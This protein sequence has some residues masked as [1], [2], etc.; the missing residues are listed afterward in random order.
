[1]EPER[2]A[3]RRPRAPSTR[4]RPRRSTRRTWPRIPAIVAQRAPPDICCGVAKRVLKPR[5]VRPISPYALI[6]QQC[7][8][9][10][11]VM[12]HAAQV[13]V[14]RLDERRRILDGH[15]CRRESS[16]PPSP[17]GRM[18]RPQHQGLP[19]VGEGA[20]MLATDRDRREAET[21]VDG[22]RHLTT[23]ADR[24]DTELTA[25]IGAP[26]VCH[27][28]GRES[29]QVRGGAEGEGAQLR[30]RPGARPAWG[31]TGL[32]RRC[33]WWR[34]RAARQRSSP[35]SRSRRRDAKPQ[36]LA[37]PATRASNRR[38]V[39]IGW[40]L[41][42]H[43]QPWIGSPHGWFMLSGNPAWPPSFSPQHHAWP[44]AVRAQ[45]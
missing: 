20:G 45:V 21:A 10:A 24:I 23:S 15:R 17:G 22:G 4:F 27:A 36:V 7:T 26:A 30:A 2:P 11:D 19:S 16:T 41:G 18:S 5:G 37:P 31:C 6:P 34:C 25:G 42:T 43:R 44:S 35:S 39:S 40:G 8:L 29:A 38:V 12:P 3:R 32:R 1:M 14:M 28:V 13:P 9:P 33:R